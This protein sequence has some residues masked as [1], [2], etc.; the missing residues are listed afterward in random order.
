[1][2]GVA[3]LLTG[4]VAPAVNFVA[5]NDI[6]ERRRQYLAALRFYR[7]FAPVYFLENSDYDIMGDPE[8]AALDNVRIRKF[9]MRPETERGKGY[10]EFAMVDAWHDSE[11][12]PPARFLKI[13]GRYLLRNVED[14]LSE[15]RGATAPTLLV[16]RFPKSRI[17]LTSVFSAGWNGYD[18]ILKGLYRRMDDSAGVWAEHIFYDALSGNPDVR[19]FIHEPDLHGVSGSTGQ[20]LH[21]PRWKWAAKQCLRRLN[22]VADSTLLYFRR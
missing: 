22:R 9:A 12:E 13:T 11:K 2:T 4:T 19:S 3:I 10:Q 8:F 16:D 1:M 5:V 17:A 14:F 20:G 6:A 15:C 7:D 21:Y 18:R